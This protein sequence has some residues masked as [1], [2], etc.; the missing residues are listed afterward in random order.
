VAVR[1]AALTG[2]SERLGALGDVWLV[3]LRE[4]VVSL[5]GMLSTVADAPSVRL[6]PMLAHDLRRDADAVAAVT[7]GLGV[8]AAGRREADQV[9]S[10][11]GAAV[12]DAGGW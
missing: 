11:L 5:N 9:V 4:A 1:L 8:D 12:G 7:N 2:T 10:T 6:L 3:S